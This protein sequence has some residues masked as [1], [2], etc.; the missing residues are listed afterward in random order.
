MTLMEHSIS[1]ET[2]VGDLFSKYQ[3]DLKKYDA[4]I[5]RDH[6][7]IEDLRSTIN[8]CGEAIVERQSNIDQTLLR[9]TSKIEVMKD[10][11]PESI[12]KALQRVSRIQVSKAEQQAEHAYNDAECSTNDKESMDARGAK[13]Q[14][15]IEMLPTDPA[16]ALSIMEIH[17]L[18]PQIGIDGTFG[19]LEQQLY[20][21]RNSKMVTSQKRGAKNYWYRLGAPPP[22]E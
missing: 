13:W 2:Y 11:S 17:D 6:K 20:K 18:L 9:K 15:L 22:V 19:A 8:E 21:Q 5:K 4:S 7:E 10:L 12:D 16:K 14:R 1:L 3:E